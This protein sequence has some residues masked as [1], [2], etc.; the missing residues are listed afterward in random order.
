METVLKVVFTG[1]IAFSN[2]FETIS[3][4]S[5][6]SP[7]I[8]DYLHMADF[9]VA[10]VECPIT[11]RV[12]ER[13]VSHLHSSHPYVG[14]LL[15]RMNMKIWNIGNNHIMDC[16]AEGIRDTI[17]CAEDNGCVTIGAGD[18]LEKA[19]K[20]IALGDYVKVGIISIA[21]PWDFVKS[22]TDKA[23][24]FTWDRRDIIA[25]R[26][27]ELR[28]ECDWVVLVVHG[29]DEFSNMPMPYVRNKYLALLELD[30]DIIV[31]HH[32]H[33][34]QNYERVGEKLIVYS[35]GNFIFD[36]D[37]QRDYAHTDVGI[38][39]SIDFEKEKYQIDYL[40]VKINRDKQI[41]EV[42][43]I[44]S[45]FCEINANE[46]ERLWPLAAKELQ[47]LNNRKWLLTQKTFPH[48]N[49]FTLTIHN[50]LGYRRVSN[51]ILMKGR[52]KSLRKTWA[53]SEL[54]HVCE[55]LQQ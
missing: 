41:V 12:F 21:K 46:Y 47:K 11:E 9:V 34:V 5:F 48:S 17:R 31:G 30:A 6:L 49:Q 43:N 53:S 40:P 29:G 35:L 2:Y 52:M 55:Y 18:S 32:P 25:Q 45:I 37:Y 1:D 42:G 50:V 7:E 10:N 16:S 36:T 8:K 14:E 23:G 26:I 54:S 39:L 24:A 27:H 3:D 44:P 33:V 51:R 38:L 20:A 15:H 28:Q 19:S 4:D 13:T 22:D